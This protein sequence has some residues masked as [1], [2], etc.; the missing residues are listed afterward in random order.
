MNKELTPVQ[1]RT[2]TDIGFAFGFAKGFEF[3]WYDG[4]EGIP[5]EGQTRK[6]YDSEYKELLQ[7]IA[8]VSSDD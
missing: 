5:F 8:E 7:K 2:I 1:L 4:D 3:G 6:M